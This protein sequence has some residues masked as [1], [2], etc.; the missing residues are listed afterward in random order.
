MPGVYIEFES[1]PNLELD[2][3]GLEPHDIEVVAHRIDGGR[4]EGPVELVTAFVPDGQVAEFIR[5]LEAYGRPTPKKEHERRYEN[6]FDRISRLRLATLKALWT[7]TTD[8]PAEGVALWWEVWLRKAPDGLELQR[9]HEYAGVVGLRLGD[10]RLAFDDRVVTLAF[11]T[12][13][14]LASSLDVLNDFAEL[15]R[16]KELATFFVS[17]ISSEQAEWSKDLIRR[18]EWPKENA[19]SVCLL[20]TG[21]NRAHPAIE[22]ALAVSDLHAVERSWGVDDDGGGP[23]CEGHGTEM[24]GLALFGDLVGALES[25]LA[26]KLKHR[27]ESVKIL[28]PAAFGENKPELYGAI[29]AAAAARPEIERPTRSRTFSLSITAEAS[30]DK[31][32]PTSW[33]SAVDALAC[34]RAFVSKT[35]GLEYVIGQKRH[36][37]LFVVSAG[38]NRIYQ[39]EYLDRCDLEEVHD[40][41]QAWNPIVVGAFTEKATLP[42]R[43]GADDVR[44]LAGVGDL[45][46]YSTTSVL[47][48]SDWPV[49]PDVVAEGGNVAAMGSDF[50][51]GEDD[52]S[53]LTTHYRPLDRTF[54]TTWATSAACAQVSRLCA[55]LMAEYERFWPES[56][57]GLVVHSAQWTPAMLGQFAAAG[58]R[59]RSR[60]ALLRR[61]G[62]G[63]PS[64]ERAS[65]SASDALTLVAQATIRP[66]RKGALREMHLF[67][68]PW[69]M[70]EL[71][72][73]GET[74][75]TL[76]VTLSY[77]VDP[78]PARRGW[79]KRH[80]YQSHGLRFALKGPTQ[81]VAQFTKTLNKKALEDGEKRPKKE[82]DDG[83]FLGTTAREKGSLHSDSWRGTAR[84]LAARGV[85]AIYPVSG[86]W[87]D[88]PARDMSEDGVRYSLLISIQTPESSTDLW[89]P[90]ANQVG[91]PVET[92]VEW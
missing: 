68:L 29:T 42:S 3:H 53:L 7:D 80:R 69:P 11:G 4:A 5:R 77:F 48:S 75:V 16:A 37:R 92:L 28:P 35:S 25:N 23:Q 84:D 51:V 17:Q 66:F 31:G 55:Q 74:V 72:S 70:A 83:W 57:R 88:Y 67:E 34:G 56:I 64:L 14:Q 47:F 22:P 52:L 33:S 15:R 62:H 79:R 59:K 85:V 40:P 65:R 63:V 44:P 32:Q 30:R 26:L 76:R 13:Q 45:S 50:Y 89:T 18:T 2:V 1:F 10:R 91:I 19:P 9:L 20:D 12:A 78:N 49:K 41:A 73:L 71:E 8:F 6:T 43:T 21:V 38:N 27:L 39:R 87:K 60:E 58:S 24:A 86:W 36:Q 81:T 54:T 90:V 46:P 82:A 61:Y